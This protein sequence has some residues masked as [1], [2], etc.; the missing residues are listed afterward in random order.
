MISNAADDLDTSTQ[1]GTTTKL[2]VAG[3]AVSKG[4]KVIAQPN[5][6][7]AEA[8]YALVWGPADTYVELDQEGKV[9]RCGMSLERTE[10]SAAAAAAIVNLIESELNANASINI[11]YYSDLYGKK[12]THETQGITK[13]PLSTDTSLPSYYRSYMGQGKTSTE[14]GRLLL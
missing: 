14:T 1:L 7:T 13:Q 9:F 10:T 4:T 3:N 2:S 11:S 5:T 12:A 6:P 8:G